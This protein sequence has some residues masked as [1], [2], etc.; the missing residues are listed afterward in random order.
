MADTLFSLELNA[1]QRELRKWLH[2]FAAEGIRPAAH[3]WDEREETPGPIIQEAAKAGIYSR[4]FMASQWVDESGLGMVIAQEE[5]FWG[6]AG[7]GL[8][9]MGTGL[10]AA[11][12]SANGTN[13]QI[14]EF[15]PPMYGSPG[16][17]KLG[18]FCSSEP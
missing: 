6:D 1:D 13:E 12:I 10:A 11:A 17:I 2:E 4:D 16:N 7:I 9:I 8:A 18:A 3:A 15:V 5:L 14:G